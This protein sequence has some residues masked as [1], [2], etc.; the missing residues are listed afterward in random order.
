MNVSNQP[1]KLGLRKLKLPPFPEIECIR[2]L[3]IQSFLPSTYKIVKHGD[4]D[5]LESADGYVQV[6]V[7]A[8]QHPKKIDYRAGYAVFFGVNHPL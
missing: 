4:Y 1:P 7:Q 8:F 3:D 5:F 6:Y 2:E